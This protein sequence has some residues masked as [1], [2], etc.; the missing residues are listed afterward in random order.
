MPTPPTS[1][2]LIDVRNIQP[3]YF[4]PGMGM[5]Y[6][7]YDFPYTDETSFGW[8]AIK[9]TPVEDSTKKEWEEQ[10]KLLSAVEY[11]P[12]TAE[13]SWFITTYLAVRDIRLF[14]NAYVR[15]SSLNWDNN[16]VLVGGF[17]ATGLNVNEFWDYYCDEAIGVSTARKW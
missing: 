15:T 5:W 4:P 8:L 1:M 16:H 7:C 14:K 2:S 6:S 9:K 3:T 10:S 11:V 13:M 17:V 12:N